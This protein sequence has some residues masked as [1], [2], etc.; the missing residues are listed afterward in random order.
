[1][2]LGIMGAKK[3][4]DL[5]PGDEQAAEN[6]ATFS[7]ESPAAPTRKKKGVFI[8]LDENGQLDRARVRDL[9]AVEQA[10][11]ALKAGESKAIEGEV[12]HITED[13]VKWAL[14]RYMDGCS[15]VI[16]AVLKS[17]SQGI[18]VIPK[19]LAHSVY[20]LKDSQLDELAPDGA[21]FFNQQFEKLPEWIKEWFLA[22]G[23]GA[24][25]FGQLA[26]ITALQTQTLVEEWKKTMPKT[27]PN[28]SDSEAVVN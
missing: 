2:F 3:R 11:A 6:P 17:R 13:H 20:Q 15:Y 5:T 16:P 19:D 14:K 27:P 7:L 25:F 24:K 26:V 18:I 23:P 22:V 9:G 28:G 12:Q 10:R 8:P 1:M 21:K 4:T